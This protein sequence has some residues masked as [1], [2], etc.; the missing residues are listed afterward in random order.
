MAAPVP[1]ADPGE[2]AKQ[3]RRRQ[4]LGAAKAVFAEAGYHGASI[5]AII[6]RAQIARGTFYLYFESKAA[7]F[8]SILD[9]AMAE[10]R[11]RI[12][13]IDVVDP[14]APAPQVQL[15]E[16]VVATLEYVVRDRALATI[17]LS[18][19]HT[20]EAEASERLEQFFTETRDLLK[21][22]METGMEIGLLRPCQPDLVAAAMLG[23][24]RGVIEFVVQQGDD[25]KVDDVVSEMLHV[26]L[27]GVLKT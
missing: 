18:A 16:Q 9:Q 27:R 17:L 3:E 4:I 12:R 24:I 2:R 13:R 25:A 22:A 8:D 20:P 11:S 1:P 10:L 23:M 14:G 26:A 7:V 21:R 5:H 19:G 15:R 6:E